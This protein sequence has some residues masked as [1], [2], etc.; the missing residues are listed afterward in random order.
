MSDPKDA[1]DLLD[2]PCEF[3]FKVMVRVTELADGETAETAIHSHISRHLDDIEILASSSAASRTG[4]FE[5][6]TLTMTVQDRDKL[7]SIYSI[8]AS[9]EHVVMTL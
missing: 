4:R 1:F 7:E 6:V 2:Y 9:H 5:S 3:Q 8:L